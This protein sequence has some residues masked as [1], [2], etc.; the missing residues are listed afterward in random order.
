MKEI[1]KT[2]FVPAVEKSINNFYETGFFVFYKSDWYELRKKY[3]NKME[4][5]CLWEQSI[6]EEW[7]YI[8]Y[9]NIFEH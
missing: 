2:Y 6:I 4:A 7:K 1:Y 3:I 5:F 8:Y 9:Q